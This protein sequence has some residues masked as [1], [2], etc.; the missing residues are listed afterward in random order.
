MGFN[1]TLYQSLPERIK[2]FFFSG[3][4]LHQQLLPHAAQRGGRGLPGRQHP[5]GC[6]QLVHQPT[7]PWIDEQTPQ[8]FSISF[9]IMHA[10]NY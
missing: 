9:H 5:L 10:G 6:D 7:Q 8:D 4:H 1:L 3:L 2:L